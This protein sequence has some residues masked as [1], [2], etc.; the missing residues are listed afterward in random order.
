M[1]EELPTLLMSDVVKLDGPVQPEVLEE[2]QRDGVL[3]YEKGGEL[4]QGI[5][6]KMKLARLVQT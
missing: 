1:D 6:D 3:L 4:F 5:A 2:I